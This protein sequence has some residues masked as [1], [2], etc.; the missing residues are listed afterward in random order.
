MSKRANGEGTIY[1]RAD[2]RYEGAAYVLMPSG[3]RA[4]RRVYG[5]T[6]AQ[7]QDQLVALVRQSQQGVPAPS[8][9]LTVG[10]Y[11]EGWL[12]DVAAVKV[13]PA[14]LRSYEM[15]LRLHIVPDLGKKRL[16]RLAPTDVR[17]FLMRKQATG[18]SVATVKQIH[19]ILR[20]A[21]S[22][23]A[24]EDLVVRNVAKLVQVATPNTEP[25]VPLSAEEAQR[26]LQAARGDRLHA[27]WAVALTVGLRRG[28]VLGLR[29]CD[30]DLSIG[31]LDVRQ[32]LQ[33]AGGSLQVV[34]PKT[35]R[36]RRTVP[37]PGITVA[38]LAEHRSRMELEA[39]AAGRSLTSTGFVFTT[40][41]GTPMEPRNVNR[42]FVALLVSAGLRH[43]RLHDL[44]HTCAT[45][46]LDQG[47]SPRVVM[48]TLGHSTIGVTMNVYAHV[49]PQAMRDAATSMH[50][51]LSR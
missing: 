28:E 25:P 50:S 4:R 8:A 31:T 33:R 37:L 19:A 11:L 48:E 21:L 27:L 30:V 47:A 38:A 12:R 51:V 1:K 32:T 41:V 20:S 36:S 5:R 44:R 16:H 42:A 39:R 3:G 13:R 9:S 10:A 49:M 15:Y 22:H 2:G 45:L 6:R 7:V 40:T 14:T 26:L 17:E 34:P 35:R 46:L 43:V 23:A 24:R 18:L 29:W